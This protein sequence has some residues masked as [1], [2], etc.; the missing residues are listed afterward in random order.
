M[1]GVGDTKWLHRLGLSLAGG[2]AALVV[3]E[4]GLRLS[5]PALP[6]LAPLL[7]RDWGDQEEVRRWT[8]PPTD[9][10]TCGDP[11]THQPR[12]LRTTS[13]GE[14]ADK[15][16][17]VVGDSLVHSWGV[18]WAASWPAVVADS[19]SSSQQVRVQ[20][21]RLGAS[22]F[23]YCRNAAALHHLLDLKPPSA[24][25]FQVFADDLERRTVVQ[26]GDEVAAVPTH[27][28]TRHSF[29]AN[30][31]WLSW[32]TRL[33]SARPERDA[34]SAG[35]ARFRGVLGGLD[36]RLEELGIPWMVALVPPAGVERCHSSTEAWS[37]CDWLLSDLDRM[38][39]ELDGM[40]LPW[41]DLRDLW[42]EQPPGTL[43][44]EE[45]AW[46]ER[47]RLPVHP[48]HAGHAA[49]GARVAEAMRPVLAASWH[50]QEAQAQR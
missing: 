6:S 7:D 11:R 8:A 19:L 32:A 29:L 25:V 27:P 21:S 23:G 30:R 3:G 44:D 36:A 48:G 18:D 42:R 14:G 28:L 9:P 2:V 17:W 46:T 1:R 4:L 33:G 37:D 22:G 34:D 10:A 35:L 43:P 49:I 50:G 47:G 38:A 41:L 39:A 12:P 16:L 45:Q 20:L 26:V 5:S 40:G 24:V 13:H 15:A 31:L